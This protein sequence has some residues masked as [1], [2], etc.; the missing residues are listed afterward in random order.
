M[1]MSV[2]TFLTQLYTIVDDWHQQYAPVL[3][4]GKVGRKPAFSDSEV[5]TLSLAQ[6]WLGFMEERAYLR[7][8]RNNHLSLFP[9]LLSQSQFNRRA[10]SLC[11]LLQRMR[12]HIVQQLGLQE[13]AFQL[14]DG[15]PIRVRHWRRYGPGHLLRLS[16]D[17]SDDAGC[18]H[19]GLGPIPSQ[20]Q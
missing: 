16:T 19:R 13:E 1:N 17:R 12:Q 5:M 2:E 9:P 18:H 4:A 3:L 10:R 6:H 8:L 11:W 15:T 14:I 7:F 20:C